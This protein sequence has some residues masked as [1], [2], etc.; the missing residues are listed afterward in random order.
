[1]KTTAERMQ[2]GVTDLQITL[3]SILFFH[4]SYENG[5]HPES[6]GSSR[7]WTD[8]KNVS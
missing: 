6:G 2:Q 4:G 8:F 7:H 3:C 5:C 1:M